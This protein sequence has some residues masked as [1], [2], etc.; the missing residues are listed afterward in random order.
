MQ[1]STA[2][3][4]NMSGQGKKSDRDLCGLGRLQK[5]Q[6]RL[7]GPPLCVPGLHIQSLAKG[8]AGCPSP[9]P[10]SASEAQEPLWA[11]GL[12]ADNSAV[13]CQ[14]ETKAEGI[15]Y[16]Q[17]FGTVLGTNFWGHE[18]LFSH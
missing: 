11:H 5:A 4:V 2:P 12:L 1:G 10:L 13:S 14:V 8:G 3:W 15:A 17:G 7:A 9:P 6:D 16:M 18:C